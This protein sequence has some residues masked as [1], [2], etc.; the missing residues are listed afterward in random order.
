MALSS[1]AGPL[2]VARG[3]WR[4]LRDLLALRACT[5]KGQTRHRLERVTFR[6]ASLLAAVV[7]RGC[8]CASH[9]HPNYL[10][11]RIWLALPLVATRPPLDRPLLELGH[12]AFAHRQAPLT[13]VNVSPRFGLIADGVRYD[14]NVGWTPQDAG[15]SGDRFVVPRDAASDRRHRR[16]FPA[17]VAGQNTTWIGPEAKTEAARSSAVWWRRPPC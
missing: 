13:P 9:L 14:A 2:Y 15:W 11:L 1:V 3:W 17:Q 4:F 5:A 10:A 6:L 8:F 12:T 7:G 16:H